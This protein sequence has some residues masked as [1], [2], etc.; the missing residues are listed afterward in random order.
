[1]VGSTFSKGWFAALRPPSGQKPANIAAHSQISL[2]RGHRLRS[3]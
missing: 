1:M 3:L 2:E